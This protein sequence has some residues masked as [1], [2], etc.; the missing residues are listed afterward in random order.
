MKRLAHYQTLEFEKI[1]NLFIDFRE[2]TNSSLKVLDFGCGKGKFLNL[3]S[4]LGFT[5]TGTDINEAYIEEANANGFNAVS[6]DTLFTNN[7]FYDFIFLSHIIEHINPEKLVDLIP[8]LVSLLAPNGRL[9]IITP[10]YGE[11][12]YHDFSHIR[13]YLP[14]SIRHAFGQTGAPISFGET[15]LIELEDIYFFKDPHRTRLWR[16]FYVGSGFKQLFTQA[17]NKC[18]DFLWDISN[19]KIGVVASWCGIYQKLDLLAFEKNSKKG[20]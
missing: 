2:A 5:V 8:S 13:P 20:M 9:I 10:T 7:E 18:F 11:R 12:F 1:H 6:L 14:Q 16:S 15:K 19:G 4:S 17:L 3:F